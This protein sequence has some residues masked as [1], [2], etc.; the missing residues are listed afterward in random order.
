MGYQCSFRNISYRP[1]SVFHY[2]GRIHFLLL[3]IWMITIYTPTLQ[4]SQT[5]SNNLFDHFVGSALKGLNMLSSKTWSKEF[6][7]V[8]NNGAN[9]FM[10]CHEMFFQLYE[11]LGVGRGCCQFFLYCVAFISNAMTFMSM[12]FMPMDVYV[13]IYI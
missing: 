13:Y 6:T 5:H 8:N 2:P 10:S 3:L 9:C 7:A 1:G 12:T 11:P 4:N